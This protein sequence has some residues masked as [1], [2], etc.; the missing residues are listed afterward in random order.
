M[1]K[2]VG[3]LFVLMC[4]VVAWAYHALVIQD[5]LMERFGS[6]G[7]YGDFQIYYHAGNGDT[8]FTLP[9]KELDGK[10]RF[11]YASWT[12][13][14][15]L[16]CRLIDFPHAL[17]VWYVLLL[18]AYMSIAFLLASQ[19]WIGVLV[20]LVGIKAWWWSLDFGNVAPILVLSCMIL[21]RS[22]T[23][24]ASL[25]SVAVKPWTALVSIVQMFFAKGSEGFLIWAVAVIGFAI[26][27]LPESTIHF[28]WK[29]WLRPS[30]S[31]FLLPIIYYFLRARG[32]ASDDAERYI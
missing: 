21:T 28:A 20:A 25:L 26:S 32:V 6:V 31:I 3:I 15:W 22:G 4:V 5:R 24:W 9:T 23:P 12:Q 1:A 16:W 29:L 14:F 8:G 18:L 30:D 2:Q 7:Q 10:A 19:G 27:F 17:F 11:F 13:C